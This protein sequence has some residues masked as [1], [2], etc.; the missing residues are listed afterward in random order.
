MSTPAPPSIELAQAAAELLAA[1]GI[2]ATVV[3]ARFIKPLDETLLVDLG[4]RIGRI[5]TIEENVLAGGFGSAVGEFYHRSAGPCVRLASL[6]LP[7]QF[8]EHGT[9]AQLRELVG[10]TPQHIVAAAKRV[11]SDE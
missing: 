2:A 11:M 7:D 1:D 8:V 4:R 10:L 3:N 6:G 9:V 5:V